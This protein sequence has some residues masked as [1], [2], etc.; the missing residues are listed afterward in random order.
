M[1]LFC[2]ILRGWNCPA[3]GHLCDSLWH[4][5]RSRF[6]YKQPFSL[7]RTTNKSTV[8]SSKGDQA[9][10]VY[11]TP[12]AELRPIF[13]IAQGAKQR[14]IYKPQLQQSFG[15]II[16]G[17]R[18]MP[19][20]SIKGIV[21]NCNILYLEL[22]YNYSFYLYYVLEIKYIFKIRKSFIII[23]GNDNKK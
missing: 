10:T 15:R 1:R 16:F 4:E 20:N 3:R 17:R 2:C 22:F 7:D 23:T 13:Q 18:I 6:L 21:G 14:S 11:K 8:W 5:L 12:W 19:G 9:G